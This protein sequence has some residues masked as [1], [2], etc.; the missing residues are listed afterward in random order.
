M[1]RASASTSAA[2]ATGSGS[3]PDRPLP[4]AKLRFKEQRELEQLPARIEALEAEQAELTGRVAD[5]A[6]YRGDPAEKSR[7]LERMD[8]LTGEIAEAYARWD[9]LE[10]RRGGG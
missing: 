8:A 6:L 7:V 3:A 9:A 2:T 1:R 5:P 10:A 4:P